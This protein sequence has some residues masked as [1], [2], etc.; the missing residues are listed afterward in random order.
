MGVF[1][2]RSLKKSISWPAGALGMP[3]YKFIERDFPH[4]V[5]IVVPYRGLRGKWD[6]INDF[7]ARHGINPHQGAGDIKMVAGISGGALLIA[8]LRKRL[9]Q[10]FTREKS[11]VRLQR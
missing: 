9:Q 1:D 11:N 8:K 6:A 5:E 4:I 7:H 2:S 3:R 10:S